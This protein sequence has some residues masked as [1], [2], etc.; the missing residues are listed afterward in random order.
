MSA[1]EK[2][3]PLLPDTANPSSLLDQ[4]FFLE[5]PGSAEIPN[6]ETCHHDKNEDRYDRRHV[7]LVLIQGQLVNPR[8]ENVGGT[9]ETVR[10]VGRAPGVEQEDD[11]EVVEIVGKAHDEQRCR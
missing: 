4:V 11:V 8:N 9:R 6:R 1:R 3:P 10:R 5:C 7:E 2:N